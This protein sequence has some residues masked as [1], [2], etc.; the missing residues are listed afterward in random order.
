MSKKIK[1]HIYISGRVQGI[2]FRANARDKAQI[3]G[4]K[5]WIRNLHDGRVEAVVEGEQSSVNQMINY[6]K[7]GPSFA[8]VDNYEIKKESPK[9]NFNSFSIRY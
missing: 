2:G 9:D 6:L 1:R 8:R 4:V 3:L 7:R 5:G